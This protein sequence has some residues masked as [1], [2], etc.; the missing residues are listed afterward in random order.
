[1]NSNGDFGSCH[2]PMISK[3]LEH[4]LFT[5]IGNRCWKFGKGFYQW[6]SILSN[7]CY[8]DGVCTLL[9]YHAMDYT[10]VLLNY[11]ACSSINTRRGLLGVRALLEAS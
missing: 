11:D 10:L 5:R 2:T 8:H 3:A 7:R 4:Y 6:I 9:R 1:M